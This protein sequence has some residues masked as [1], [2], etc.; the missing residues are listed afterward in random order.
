MVSAPESLPQLTL[1]VKGGSVMI[2]GIEACMHL[3][4][5]FIIWFIYRSPNQPTTQLDPPTHP[6]SS[7]VLLGV[8]AVGARHGAAHGP[9]GHESRGL[10]LLRGTYPYTHQ[11]QSC[12]SVYFGAHHTTGSRIFIHFH[13]EG[14][15]ASFLPLLT[16]PDSHPHPRTSQ[17]TP[18][19]WRRGTR[20][21]LLGGG[22]GINPLVSILRHVAT[23]LE[24][25]EEEKASSGVSGNGSGKG[26]AGFRVSLVHCAGRA[27][28]RMWMGLCGT[29]S[30]SPY[31]SISPHLIDMPQ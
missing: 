16:P 21:V 26:A 29:I 5:K 1:A 30:Q 23:W 13:P 31:P 8:R 18:E 11:R 20:L 4:L 28:V 6:Q 10:L 9:R 27:D 24:G 14:G 25:P 15:R 19:H 7:L 3:A 17:M 22:V 2:A 12:F